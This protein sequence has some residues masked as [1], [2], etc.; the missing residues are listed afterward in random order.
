LTWRQTGGDLPS[1]QAADLVKQDIQEIS[2]R[3]SEAAI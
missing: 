2:D 1:Q 3:L